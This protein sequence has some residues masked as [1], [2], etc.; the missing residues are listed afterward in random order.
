MARFTIGGGPQQRPP[1]RHPVRDYVQ[2]TSNGCP[3]EEGEE[4]KN[5]DDD[6]LDSARARSGISGVA[7]D[8]VEAII[9]QLWQRRDDH[10]PVPKVP[11][12]AVGDA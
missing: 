11:V 10:G 6:Y 5:G 4:T 3:Q 8:G 12:S 1:V 7:R 9:T 2:E